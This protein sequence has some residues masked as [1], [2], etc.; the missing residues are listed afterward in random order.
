MAHRAHGCDTWIMW[1]PPVRSPRWL[2][3]VGAVLFVISPRCGASNPPAKTAPSNEVLTVAY[4]GEAPVVRQ[5]DKGIQEWQATHHAFRAIK[6][7]TERGREPR[8]RGKN[9]VVALV[10]IVSYKPGNVSAFVIPFAGAREVVA[11]VELRDSK[12]RKENFRIKLDSRPL[13]GLPPLAGNV[14]E[15]VGH[16][17]A[18]RASD[19]ARE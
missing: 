16:R 14:A 11:T 12:G 19:F 18:A 15:R 3:L 8:A 6:H 7:Y 17:V 13:W 4:E 5:I 1:H 10:T 2:L 9:E